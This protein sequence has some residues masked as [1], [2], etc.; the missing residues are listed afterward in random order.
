MARTFFHGFFATIIFI[1]IV[2]AVLGVIFLFT[3]YLS[4]F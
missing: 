4:S 3:S 2:A 1:A